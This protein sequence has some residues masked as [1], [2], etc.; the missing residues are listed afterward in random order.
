MFALS[1][2]HRPILLSLSLV[3]LAEAGPPDHVNNRSSSS[4]VHVR[5]LAGSL[6][7][8]EEQTRLGI[9]VVTRIGSNFEGQTLGSDTVE[10][11]EA[12]EIKIKTLDSQTYTLR[13]DK[14]VLGV[15]AQVKADKDSIEGLMQPVET[16]DRL[17]QEIQMWL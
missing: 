10:G 13:V 16:A 14:R 15:L 2:T 7:L 11:S 12:I 1:Q 8:S 5:G 3:S 4:S 9:N 6:H 17:F